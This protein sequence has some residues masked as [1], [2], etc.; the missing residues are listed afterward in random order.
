MRLLFDADEKSDGFRRGMEEASAGRAWFLEVRELENLFLDPELLHA[1]LESLTER[2]DLTPP[3][4]AA[5]AARVAEML[6][7]TGDPE[8]YPN[9]V[10]EGAE[11]AAA[12]VA[13]RVLGRL[14]WEFL[15]CDYE[16]VRDG[17]V[18]ANLALARKPTVLEPLSRVTRELLAD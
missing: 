6:A 15:S 7:A 5:V 8:L 17:R 2:L 1:A 12:I 13:S 10:A 9:G 4:P 18:L 11:P 16:K 14:W 3:E